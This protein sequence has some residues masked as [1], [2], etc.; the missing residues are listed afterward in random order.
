MGD[1]VEVFKSEILLSAVLVDDLSTITIELRADNT[2]NT[3]IHGM[4]WFR[5]QISGEYHL[6]QDTVIFHQPPYSNDFLPKKILIDRLDSALYF[7]LHSNGEY[8]RTKGLVNFFEILKL[9]L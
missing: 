6:S 7:E 2:F 8:N 9:K 1:S 4:F 5:D 3:T